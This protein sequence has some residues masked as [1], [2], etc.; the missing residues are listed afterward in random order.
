MFDLPGFLVRQLSALGL[1]VVAS[2]DD[3][4]CADEQRFFSYRRSVQRGEDDYGRGLAAI[5]LTE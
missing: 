5:M 2:T 3:D 4:T 1:A